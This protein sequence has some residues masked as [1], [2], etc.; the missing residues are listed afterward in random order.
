MQNYKFYYLNISQVKDL[1]WSPYSDILAIICHQSKTSKAVS[2]IGSVIQLWIENNS[3]W[4]LKQTLLFSVENPLLYATWSNIVDQIDKEELIYLT[5]E[6]LTFCSFNWCV[7][8]SRGETIDDKVVIGVIDG[9]GIKVTGFRDAIIPPPM[10]H[11]YLTTYKSQ[12]AI[13]FAPKIN[14][15]SEINT[16]EI[17]TVSCNNRLTFFKQIKVIYFYKII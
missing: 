14:K 9:N 16:N 13:I 15:S 12:N 3:H 7:N 10:S 5:T 1:L 2:S 4:Y 11:E 8:H 6:E 17:C